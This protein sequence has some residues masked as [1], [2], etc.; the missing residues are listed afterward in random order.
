MLSGFFGVCDFFL[1]RKMLIHTKKGLLNAARVQI[2]IPS[3][4]DLFNTETALQR[5]MVMVEITPHK[6]LKR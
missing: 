5:V 1:A 4:Y 6:A 2:C 3:S